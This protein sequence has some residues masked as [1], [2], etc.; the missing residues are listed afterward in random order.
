MSVGPGRAAAH[1]LPAH[2][3]S[4][5]QRYPHL[6]LVTGAGSRLI[7]ADVWN[8]GLKKNMPQHYKEYYSTWRQGPREHI[9]SRPKV[10]SFEKDE[11]GEIHPV[12]N[13]RIHV[14]YPE[15][16]H[17]GLWGGEGVVKG[18]LKRK[19]GTHRNFEPPA[20]KYWW[21]TL[22]EGVVHSEILGRHI[23]M[24]VTKRGVR[25]VD[26]AAGF[27]SYL[28]STPVNEVYA[29]GLLR[30]KRE[31]LLA[32]ASP[33]LPDSLVTKYNRFAL[34]FE[35][36]DWHGL[37]MADARKK[38]S[39]INASLELAAKVPDKVVFRQQLVEELRAGRDPELEGVESLGAQD[40]GMLGGFKNI[41]GRS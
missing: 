33:G 40:S 19:D 22:F 28:L 38:Q 26:E 9:H 2:L 32:L 1:N 13:P 11:W 4:L 3:A 20:A 35:E 23:E 17:Q 16:F 27:D 8:L 34:P 18:M 31:L 12:Q 29:T 37:T 7:A 10:A 21:P 5:R 24:V 30:L 25:L 39:R 6:A 15:Q 41:F 36:A 14:I